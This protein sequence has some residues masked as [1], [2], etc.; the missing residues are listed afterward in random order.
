MNNSRQWRKGMELIHSK[1]YTS[2]DRVSGVIGGKVLCSSLLI[3]LA[4]AGFWHIPAWSAPS[5]RSGEPVVIATIFSET[6]LAAEASLPL[7]RCVD[8]AVE[9]INSSGG[10]LGRPVQLL[11]LDNESTVIGSR[12]AAVKAIRAGVSGVI[13]SYWS[14]HS[15]VIA[16]IF[17]EAAIPMITPSSTNPEITKGMDYIFRLC[18]LD[19][20]QGKAAGRYAAVDLGTKTSAVLR[21]VDQKYS[22]ELADYF[23]AGYEKFGGHVAFEGEYRGDATDFTQ[24]IEQ[25]IRLDPEL[26]Y[27]PGYRRDAGLLVRQARAMGVDALFLGGDGWEDPSP[28]AGEALNGSY[29]T[30]H[31]YP[32]Y[33]NDLGRK[34]QQLYRERYGDESFSPN[35]FLAYDSVM[36]LRDAMERAG[37]TT[38]T[39]AI[40]DALAATDGF[41]GITGGV[42]FDHNGDPVDRKIIFLAYENGWSFV[43]GISY[44]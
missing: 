22:V 5:V 43:K 21:N 34:V 27:L 7:I 11:K 2:A 35:S 12:N 30:T 8:L 26:V 36:V 44:P 1:V 41:E 6:G 23:Q 15:L 19:S 3:L 4:L 16:P 9:Q 25:L 13:G 32:G 14:S 39:G 37:S 31:Y 18:F 17:Q 42:A 33:T 24:V 20:V 38:D 28:I 40:R 29:K 10:I